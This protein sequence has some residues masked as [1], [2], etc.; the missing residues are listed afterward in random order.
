MPMEKKN[1]SLKIKRNF[2]QVISFILFR[3]DCP[4][5]CFEFETREKLTDKTLS[6][7]HEI[8]EG[9][10]S[11]SFFDE[12]M[13]R[14][15]IALIPLEFID[16]MIIGYKGLLS[17]YIKDYLPILFNK[18]GEEPYVFTLKLKSINKPVFLSVCVSNGRSC[19]GIGYSSGSLLEDNRYSKKEGQRLSSWIFTANSTNYSSPPPF[20][21]ILRDIIEGIEEG[22]KEVIESPAFK[23]S[24]EKIKEESKSLAKTT[25]V[26]IFAAI[27]KRG[28]YGKAESISKIAITEEGECIEN[29]LSLNGN[30]SLKV[31]REYLIKKI[32]E[33]YYLSDIVL[34]KYNE[35]KFSEAYQKFL[36]RN[37]FKDLYFISLETIK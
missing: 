20:N 36:K 17:G 9:S 21:L 24:R 14:K 15:Q 23:I 29:M 4:Q 25:K 27:K 12:L 18:R 19:K 22:F 11:V 34:P 28:R 5:I 3:K 33:F 10:L 2:K 8:I 32:K 7:E 30:G 16:K 13:L 26:F 6:L 35:G 37:R 31:C 1:Y